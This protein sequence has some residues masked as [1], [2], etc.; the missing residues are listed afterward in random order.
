M[1]TIVKDSIG[2]IFNYADSAMG[3]DVMPLFVPDGHWYGRLALA[4]RIGRLGKNISPKFATR[5]LEGVGPVVLML[6]GTCEKPEIIMP[7]HVIMDS[8]VTTG[9]FEAF[10]DK[11]LD[12]CV[13]GECQYA[14]ASHQPAI[15]ALVEITRW[16]TV[17]TGDLIVPPQPVVDIELEPNSYITASVN[18]Q[19]L[20]KV[21]VK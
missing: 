20:L 8:A 4:Y 17:K 16:A 5:Y 9:Q 6:P 2:N 11:P 3:R 7:Y 12:I 15:D 19:E 1:K 10:E 18:S 13:N 21:K 14:I